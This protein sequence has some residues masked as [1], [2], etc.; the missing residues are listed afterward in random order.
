MEMWKFEPFPYM[1]TFEILSPVLSRNMK[2]QSIPAFALLGV[3]AFATTI[4]G[5]ERSVITSKVFFDIRIGDDDVGR[6]ELGLYGAVVPRTV[7]YILTK[8]T[9]VGEL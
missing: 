9:L 8:L 7:F 5:A 6:I 1:V 3:L 4:F 2:L